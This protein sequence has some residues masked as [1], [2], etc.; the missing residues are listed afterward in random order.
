M[1]ESDVSERD[2]CTKVIT[3]AVK[4]AG[5]DEMNQIREEVGFTK[6]RIIVR[7]TP[8]L[9]DGSMQPDPGHCACAFIFRIVR[10]PARGRTTHSGV[11]SLMLTLANDH[12]T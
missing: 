11:T 5:C 10:G 6:G 4:Q 8:T 7:G 9:L 1:N 2:I 12:W 3:P